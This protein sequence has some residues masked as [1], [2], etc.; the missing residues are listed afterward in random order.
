MIKEFKK[1]KFISKEKIADTLGLE[2]LN[3]VLAPDLEELMRQKKPCI[4]I[5]NFVKT[6]YAQYAM[7][8]MEDWYFDFRHKNPKFIDTLSIEKNNELGIFRYTHAEVNKP[9]KDLMSHVF[10]EFTSSPKKIKLIYKMLDSMGNVIDTD[11]ITFAGDY[12]AYLIGILVK[13]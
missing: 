9:L 1:H 2:D 6:G 11:P 7:I 13:Y 12:K 3:I 5:D 10:G 4:D 8:N